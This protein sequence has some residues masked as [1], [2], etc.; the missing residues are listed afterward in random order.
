MPNYCTKWKPLRDSSDLRQHGENKNSSE[1][2][3][4]TSM[5][6]NGASPGR[7]AAENKKE[8]VWWGAHEG[9]WQS[10]RY[11]N[12]CPVGEEG[13]ILLKPPKFV[14][15]NILFLVFSTL[16]SFVANLSESTSSSFSSRPHH[17]SRGSEAMF[18]L[19]HVHYSEAGPRKCPRVPGAKAGFKVCLFVSPPTLPS[20]LSSAWA[21]EVWGTLNRPLWYNKK[22]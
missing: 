3:V 16:V 9:H 10:T 2:I 15:E 12:R 20:W 7:Q 11:C 19:L 18:W 4:G 6:R 5:E 13:E 22:L 21:K 14:R 8:A 1:L 17:L